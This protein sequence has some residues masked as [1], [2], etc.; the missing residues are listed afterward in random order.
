MIHPRHEHPEVGTLGRKID[1]ASAQPEWRQL[2][3]GLEINAKGQLRTCIP[4]NEAALMIP[5]AAWYFHGKY[6]GAHSL[7]AI[8]PTLGRL[9]FY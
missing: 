8:L 1:R 2:K 3:P 5:A 7:G 9:S 4:E 6:A